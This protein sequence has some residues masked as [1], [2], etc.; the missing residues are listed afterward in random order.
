V[1][2]LGYFA[3]QPA[4]L[5]TA[6]CEDGDRVDLLV[7]PPQTARD[8]VDAAMVLAASTSNL[9]HAQHVLLAVRPAKRRGAD[10]EGQ[11]VWEAEGGRLGPPHGRPGTELA[12]RH[13]PA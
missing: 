9:I 6:Q 12:S 8:I 3:S 5:L 7:V 11:D 4:G 2:R 10:S 13:Q 1:L